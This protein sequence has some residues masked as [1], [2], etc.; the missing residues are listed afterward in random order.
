MG[1]EVSATGGLGASSAGLGEGRSGD[2]SG[3]PSPAPTG[4]CQTSGIPSR[5]VGSGNLSRPSQR[6]RA[7]SAA[8]WSAAAVHQDQLPP[9]ARRGLARQAG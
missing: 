6:N 5:M 4:P 3:A 7:V 2:S 9:R 8:P 1:G